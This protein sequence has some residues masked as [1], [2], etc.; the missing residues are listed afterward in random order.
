MTLFAAVPKPPFPLTEFSYC[1]ETRK[2]WLIKTLRRLENGR[3]PGGA[4]YLGDE[5]V[6]CEAGVTR[7]GERVVIVDSLDL[8]VIENP[9]FAFDDSPSAV[10]RL[11][12]DGRWEAVS[13]RT[14]A[15]GTTILA[16]V[17]APHRPAVF[18]LV[19]PC[20]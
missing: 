20:R 15:A 6:L 19:P 11:T 16:T 7:R 5:S 10:E 3:L 18:R 9:E 4:A 13:A 17:L 1:N 2:A 14:S 12:D 8:D